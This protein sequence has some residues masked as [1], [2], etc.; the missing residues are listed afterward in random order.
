[1]FIKQ[2]MFEL[3]VWCGVDFCHI[4]VWFVLLV[5][6]QWRQCD[7]EGI[8]YMHMGDNSWQ[9]I[10]KLYKKALKPRQIDEQLQKLKMW[11]QFQK[12]QY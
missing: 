3:M 10:N 12:M 11:N 2:D 5:I 4:S 9:K 6:W 8:K 1:M 7:A